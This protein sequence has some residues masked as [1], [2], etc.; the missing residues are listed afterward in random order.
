MK[1]KI[2]TVLAFDP[3]EG[4]GLNLQ[5]FSQFAKRFN[6]EVL[7]LSIFSDLETKFVGSDA[8]KVGKIQKKIQEKLRR[9]RNFLAPLVILQKGGSRNH[10]V[11]A[12]LHQVNESSAEMIA[13]DSHGRSGIRRWTLGSFAESLLNRSSKP[14]LFLPKSWKVGNFKK[15]QVLFPTDFSEDSFQAYQTFLHLF[16]GRGVTV[17]LY[18]AILFP[19]PISSMEVPPSAYVPDSFFEEQRM[20]AENQAKVWRKIAEDLG[21]A[22][23]F[24]LEEKGMGFLSGSELM[25][26][27]NKMKVD[28]IGISSRSGAFDRFFAG[29]SAFELFRKKRLPVWVFG[30]NCKRV[31]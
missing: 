4:E 9:F 10:A 20:W 31:K 11:D 22:F 18:H 17:N 21:F 25:E 2:R 8:E 7:S 27:A 12:F 30:P 16:S 19:A 23:A 26:M 28:F 24:K 5:G 29:S 3:T 14:L 15:K 6:I 13:V 1:K